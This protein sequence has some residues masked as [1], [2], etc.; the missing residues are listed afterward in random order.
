MRIAENS[1][2]RLVLR[3]RTWWI[4]VICLAAGAVLVANVLIRGEGEEQYFGAALFALFALCGV[5]FLRATE[6][7]L[8]RGA[9]SCVIR[10]LDIWRWQETRL[11]FGQITNVRVETGPG[12]RATSPETCRLSLLTPGGPVP[13]TAA[14][15]PGLE[16]YGAMR[17]AIMDMVFKTSP[18]PAEPDPVAALVAEGRII[19]AV[20]LLRKRE[21][22]DLTTARTR[23]AEIQKRGAPV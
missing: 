23:V 12:Q 4:S 19:D 20:V 7:V 1:P 8:D 6:V 22:L 11:N 16:R 9:R 2:A 15:E 17:E 3:D 18:R 5:A 21:K 13:L 14:Y 10:R